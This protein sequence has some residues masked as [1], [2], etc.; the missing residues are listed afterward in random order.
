LYTFPST[1]TPLSSA[2]PISVL[3][4]YNAIVSTTTE[5]LNAGQSLNL[6]GQLLRLDAGAA[7][8]PEPRM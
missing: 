4:I 8:G 2:T 6:S 7:G 1:I 5:A 3:P